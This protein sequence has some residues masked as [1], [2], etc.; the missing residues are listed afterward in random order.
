MSAA[1]IPLPTNTPQWCDFYFIF[2]NLWLWQSEFDEYWPLIST[3]YTKIGGLLQQQNGELEVQKYECRLR[4]SKKGGK[5][6]PTAGV[7]KCYGATIRVPGLC[8]VRIK[9]SR[10]VSAPITIT[11]QRLDEYEHRHT[12]ERSREIAPSK[13]VLYLAATE[14]AKGHTPAQVLNALRGIGEHPRVL[15]ALLKYVGGAHLTRYRIS[16][17][18]ILV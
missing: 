4:K 7:K 17:G 8:V 3:V 10:T 15:N 18:T 16:T 9:T 2:P 5:P 12:L 6:P 1:L 11:I 14:A 13:L